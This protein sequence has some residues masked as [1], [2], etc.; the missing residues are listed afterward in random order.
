L[1]ETDGWK[2]IVNNPWL[3]S[4]RS[5]TIHAWPSRHPLDWS[6]GYVGI[7]MGV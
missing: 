5:A 7:G 6:M 2:P 1:P 4:D 3:F